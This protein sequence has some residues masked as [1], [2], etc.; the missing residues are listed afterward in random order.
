MKSSIPNPVGG[1]EGLKRVLKPDS[2]LHMFEHTGSRW[3]QFSIMMKGMSR[4]TQRFGPELDR[5]TVTN[6]KA[7]GFE[8]TEVH[9]VRLDTM[10]TIHA[11]KPAA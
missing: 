9:H 1:L 11:V 5:D 10:K 2:E 3:F 6:A 7:A 8:L 4:I